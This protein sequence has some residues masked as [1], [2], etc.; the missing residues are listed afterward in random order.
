MALIDELK[1]KNIHPMFCPPL[2]EHGDAAVKW[3]GRARSCSD[4]FA[5]YK[6]RARTD[7]FNAKHL[8]RKKAKK[9][10]GQSPSEKR[11]TA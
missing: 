9:G 8:P 4:S 3:R 6:R 11:A 2:N 1:K 5:T 7:E 10:I